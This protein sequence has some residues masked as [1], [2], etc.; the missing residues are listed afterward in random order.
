MALFFGVCLAGCVD[1]TPWA[2]ATAFEQEV[3]CDTTLDQVTTMAEENGM[4]I[5]VIPGAVPGLEIVKDNT[6]FQVAYKNDRLQHL[7]RHDYRT[8]QPGGIKVIRAIDM[9]FRCDQGGSNFG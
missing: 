9:V 3:D 7:V 1:Q 2:G 5:A 8:W 4:Q 6:T